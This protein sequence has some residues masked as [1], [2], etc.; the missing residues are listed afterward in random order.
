[1]ARLQITYEGTP[2]DIPDRALPGLQKQAHAYNAQTDADLTLAQFLAL[3][4]REMAIAEQL[5]AEHPDLQRQAQEE[6]E[7]QLVA[8][9]DQLIAD[10]DKPA[11]G[12]TA[13]AQ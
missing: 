9:R 4:L 8:R 12:G 3:H 10:L 11:L 7:R 2:H 13:P 6:A 1:M 5:A